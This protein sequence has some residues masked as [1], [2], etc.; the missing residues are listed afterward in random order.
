MYEKD[1]LDTIVNELSISLNE[2]NIA[3]DPDEILGDEELLER[4]VSRDFVII[5]YED[6]VRF[7]YEY[8]SRYR[9]NLES[10]KSTRLLIIYPGEDSSINSIPYDVLSKAKVHKYNLFEIF[11]QFSYQAVKDLPRDLYNDLYEIS[12]QVE[13]T[14]GTNASIDLILKNLYNL[15]SND[16]HSPSD[17]LRTLLQFQIS[18]GFLPEEYGRRFTS[19]IKISHQSISDLPL[20]SFFT[21]KGYF[22]KVLQDGW[23]KFI[24]YVESSRTKKTEWFFDV[25]L[26][27]NYEIQPLIQKLFK[28][29]DLEDVPSDIVIN[30]PPAWYHVGLVEK[31]RIVEN[32]VNSLISQ[33][34]KQI[35]S[36]SPLS[37]QNWFSIADQWA[38]LKQLI[39]EHY[40]N[41]NDALQKIQN[42][43]DQAFIGWL[44]KNF[45]TLSTL[46]P[47]PP[48][49]VH[50]IPEYLARVLFENPKKKIALIVLDGMAIWQW[51]I[52]KKNLHDI[53][54]KL[55]FTQWTAFA[56]IP[57]VT[58]ISRQAIFSGRRPMFFQD[59][60]ETTNAEPGLWENFWVDKGFNT[61]QIQYFR[62]AENKDIFNELFPNNKIL[63]LIINTIDELMHGIML[64]DNG[65]KNQVDQW[66]SGDNLIDIIDQLLS[67]DYQVFL[68][69]DHGNVETSK[70]ISINDGI[71]ASSKGER[72]RIYSDK[73]LI[74]YVENT[75][76][77]HS[78]GLPKCIYP[79]IALDD[80]SF[81][82]GKGVVVAHGGASLQEVIVPF[83]KVELQNE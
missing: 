47:N 34:E 17:L 22:L 68:T 5:R 11:S 73:M 14:L 56:W 32:K 23:E 33:I 24:Q 62:K 13:N 82:Q 76:I 57:T 83:I 10:N 75:I 60:L 67:L 51:K 12:G 71:L 66:S 6:P 49:V 29:G 9:E 36:E 27:E 1:F 2:I 8:E 52:I 30:E 40:K 3:V 77:W 16:I 25:A 39:L 79:V 19:K 50:Q 65:M 58:S 21:Q 53:N 15:N 81:K 69:S 35:D 64:G 28:R 48:K 61:S 7:R 18:F 42:K 63:G 74:P 78:S 54:E 46:P 43:I 4:L 41:S 26:F 45:D 59:S 55:L 20:L 38:T 44:E 72:V 70:T 37:Y 31:E 80:Y